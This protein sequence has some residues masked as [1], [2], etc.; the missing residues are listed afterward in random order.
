MKDATYYAQQLRAGKISFEQ[1]LE[2]ILKKVAMHQE[3]N[4][5]VGDFNIDEAKKDYLSTKD[6]LFAGLLIPLK[7]L[8]QSKEGWINSGASFLLKD[9]IASQT[10]NF[11]KTMTESGLTPFGQTNAPEFGFKNIS[12]SR[13]YGPVKN[14]WNLDYFAGGSSGGAAAAVAAGIFPM[15]GASDGGGSIRIPASFTGLIGLKP[16]RGSMPSGPTSFRDWQGASVPFALTVSMRDTKA[17]FEALNKPTTAAPYQAPFYAQKSMPE[18][19]SLKIAYT[20]VSPIKESISK[21]A[22]KAVSDAVSFLQQQ[23]HIVKEIPYPIDGISLIQDYYKM[24]GAE[25]AAMMEE[26]SQALGRD[27]QKE[28]VEWM[29]W[30]IYQ[31]GLKTSAA[32][33][34]QSLN[35]WDQA[36]QVMEDLFLDYDLFLTPT[37]AYP[38]PQIGVPL[39]DEEIFTALKNAETLNEQQLDDLVYRMFEKSLILTPFTQL[40]NLT[41]QPAISLPTHLTQDHLPLGIHFMSAKGRED[42][43]FEIGFLFEAHHKFKLPNYYQT[44]EKK[45]GN[46]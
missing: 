40:A 4:A 16:T 36:A 42:L 6:G 38:A 22:K 27:I 31:A 30:G 34:V 29:T 7:V 46:I 3:L 8:G 19:K 44:N 43:L 33:Y 25:T 10:S 35:S 32:R 11:V 37:T 5:F 24:N 18:K 23:G 26:I 28:D 45:E 12:D 21:E 41:G 2:E 9:Q 20:T 1:L 13:L 15:A 39:Q 14:P 17:L